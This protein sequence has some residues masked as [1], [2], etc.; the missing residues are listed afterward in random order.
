MNSSFAAGFGLAFLSAAFNG[1]YTIP[2][3]ISPK[4]PDP[5]IFNAVQN[6]GIFLTCMAVAL[7]SPLWTEDHQFT[8]IWSWWGALGGA[9]QAIVGCFVFA[10]I[11]LIPLSIA[12]PIMC[13][14]AVIVSFGWGSVGPDAVRKPVANIGLTLAG[15]ALLLM[16]ALTI[17][18]AEKIADRLCGK[19]PAPA[20]ENDVKEEEG[21]VVTLSAMSGGGSPTTTN[22]KTI[23]VECG[24][25][26]DAGFANIAD[27]AAVTSIPE[28]KVAI[29][30][31]KK[32]LAA[33]EPTLASGNWLQT[34]TGVASAFAAGS[35]GASTMVPT[36]FAP[37]SEYGLDLLPSFGIAAMA[38]GL[39]IGTVYWWVKGGN[40]RLK[41]ELSG[42]VFCSSII[43]GGFIWNLGNIC[44]F[45]AQTVFNLPYGVAY[46]VFQLGLVFSFLWAIFY[47]KEVTGPQIYVFWGGASF[48]LGGAI[49]LGLF[50]PRA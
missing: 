38:I 45:M 6:C 21:V 43:A 8:L 40:R 44:Q 1:S 42:G 39:T 28:A 30:A 11:A 22:P 24:G 3:K 32:E 36:A 2:M 27:H 15:M 47:F 25:K 13:C 14:T 16:G 9:I 31:P 17:N 35:I 23:D 26:V 48:V 18:L 49:M 10:S 5:V 33:G 7:F 37:K 41:D 20:E 12:S 50:G 19:K 34:V 29:D 4:K 46:P